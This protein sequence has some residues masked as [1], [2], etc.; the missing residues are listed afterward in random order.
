M[1]RGSISLI[2]SLLL[3]LPIVLKAQ[4]EE[5]DYVWLVLIDLES[6]ED[7][8][9]SYTNKFDKKKVKLE[10]SMTDTINS[11]ED[12]IYEEDQLAGP[13]CFVPE[14]KLVFRYY[15]YVISLYCSKAIKF[16]NE[17]PF[18]A[19]SEIMPGELI[20][21][22][23]VGDY[24]SHLKRTH[25]GRKNPNQNLIQQIITDPL[26][27]FSQSSNV[28]LDIFLTEKQGLDDDEITTESVQQGTVSPSKVQAREEEIQELEK[29]LEKEEEKEEKKTE[30]KKDKPNG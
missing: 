9:L 6:K 7:I 14:I 11:L 12:F 26:T 27:S 5:E 10:F 15:T 1:K 29:K 4:F 13:E 30:K 20:F 22:A 18:Q 8:A 25:F 28:D 19:T 2:L 23:S 21:T 3:L 16:K 24:L 17:S